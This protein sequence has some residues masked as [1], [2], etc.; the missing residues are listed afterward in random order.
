MIYLAI[1]SKRTGGLFWFAYS[2]APEL[3]GGKEHAEL[4]AELEG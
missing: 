1:R 3:R 4:V 2:L